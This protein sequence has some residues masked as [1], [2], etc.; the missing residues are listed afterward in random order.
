VDDLKD[1]IK[2][3]KD[4]DTF[5]VT[6]MRAGVSKTIDVHYPKELKTSNL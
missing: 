2:D 5:K 1:A 4:G 3:G 6:Y